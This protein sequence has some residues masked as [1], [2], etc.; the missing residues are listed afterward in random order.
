MSCLGRVVPRS[1]GLPRAD[2]ADCSPKLLPEGSEK[3]VLRA[4]HAALVEAVVTDPHDT[5]GLR[6][7]TEAQRAR[8]VALVL[9]QEEG[10]EGTAGFAAALCAQVEAAQ[11]RRGCARA[12]AEV[13][14][15]ARGVVLRGRPEG[16]GGEASEYVLYCASR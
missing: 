5:H 2:G 11:W 14:A 7:A 13:A 9:H 12:L 10:E 8:L 6:G 16:A 1:V 15:W 4:R 3:L